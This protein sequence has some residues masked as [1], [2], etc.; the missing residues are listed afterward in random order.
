MISAPVAYRG[1]TSHLRGHVQVLIGA[2]QPDRGVSPLDAQMQELNREIEQLK[3]LV[4]KIA[5]RYQQER[6]IL[7]P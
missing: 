4:Q 7:N 2:R 1:G 6:A 5:E 3:A